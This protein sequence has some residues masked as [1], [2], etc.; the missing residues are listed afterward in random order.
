MN[1]WKEV[2]DVHTFTTV[3]VHE[4]VSSTFGQFVKD[5]FGSWYRES[6]FFLVLF[7]RR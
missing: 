7:E 6:C 3:L 1:G 4:E 2:C 5:A